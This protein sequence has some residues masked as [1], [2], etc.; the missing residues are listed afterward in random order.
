[1]TIAELQRLYA[2]DIEN[3][4][5]LEGF[6]GERFNHYYPQNRINEISTWCKMLSLGHTL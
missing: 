2:P 6:L 4:R 5:M 3:E 1:M